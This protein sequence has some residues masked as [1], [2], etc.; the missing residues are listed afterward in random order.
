ML[1]VIDCEQACAFATQRFHNVISV[2]VHVCVCSRVHMIW[3]K[4]ISES[5]ELGNILPPVVHPCTCAQP[6]T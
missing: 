5:C 4:K 2:C 6:H 3:W 1:H